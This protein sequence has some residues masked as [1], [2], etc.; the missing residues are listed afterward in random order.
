MDVRQLRYFVE[1][2]DAESF[3][4]AAE[5]IHV[6][7]PA[8]GFQV[9]KLEEEL[10]T[11]VLLRHSRGVAPTE[12]GLVLYRHARAILGQVEQAKLEVQDISGPP[13][14]SVTL[15]VTP[16][17]TGLLATR[18]VRECGA[19]YPGISLN[20]VEGLSEDVV[21]RLSENRIDMGFTY[22][23]EA[24]K[25]LRYEP[26]LMEDLFYIGK[27][28]A[29][30]PPPTARSISLASVLEH[31]LIL[32]SRPHGVRRWLEEA[33][34][35]IGKTLTVSFEIDSVATIRE[36]VESGVGFSVLPL[37]AIQSSVQGG[38]IFGIRI[39]RPRISRTL[40]LGYS[41]NYMESNATRAVR[42]VIDLV[43]AE[44]IA[45]ERGFWR[46]PK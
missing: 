40:H 17:S 39:S 14:G 18:L 25:G 19:R 45:D 43:V 37:G 4:K 32:P 28:D 24:A 3:T 20:L 27:R 2:V 6:A 33:A 26:L 13:R 9:R 41:A 11:E 29:G 8:L 10:G 42:E 31:P 38:A 36:L 16:T 23:P 46:T 44:R 34:A 30:E 7:Q 35:S 15:A 1:V 22:N 5:T 21:R 12:A